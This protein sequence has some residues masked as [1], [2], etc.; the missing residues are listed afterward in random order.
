[1]VIKN[2]SKLFTAEE[3]AMADYLDAEE[4]KGNKKK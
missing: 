2:R 3:N 4:V 1:M